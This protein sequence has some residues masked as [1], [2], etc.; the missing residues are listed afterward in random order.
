VR[1]GPANQQLVAEA[2]KRLHVR[3]SRGA[4]DGERRAG[5]GRQQARRIVRTGHEGRFARQGRFD[6]REAGAG[7]ERSRS[8]RR[9]AS[10]RCPGGLR[11]ARRSRRARS[12]AP[13]VLRERPAPAGNERR[14]VRPPAPGATVERGLRW[15][16]GARRGTSPELRAPPPSRPRTPPWTRNLIGACSRSVRPE[17][18]TD[19]AH[20]LERLSA[21]RLV[22]L[23]AEVADVDVDTF[24][25]FS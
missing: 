20:R 15:T 6:R 22:D 18:V 10:T 21:K 5:P 9:V 17:P 23:A 13:A 3:L 7:E 4:D 16:R 19:A 2:C 12:A 8:Q 1:S 25:R 14:E 11:A 24:E